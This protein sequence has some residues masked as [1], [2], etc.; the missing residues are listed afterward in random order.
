MGVERKRRGQVR[1]HDCNK[2]IGLKDVVEY[3]RQRRILI[4]SQKALRIGKVE[5]GFSYTFSL[6]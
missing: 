5:A 1:A 6:L 4:L 3:R 2:L